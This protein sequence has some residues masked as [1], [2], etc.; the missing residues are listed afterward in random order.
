VAEYGILAFVIYIATSLPIYGAFV[1]ASLFGFSLGE[2]T[3]SAGN[4][5]T[6][7]AALAAAWLMLRALVPARVALTVA[8]TPC[9]ARW[10]KRCRKSKHLAS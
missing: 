7:F 1:A 2:A 4:P 6:V 9:I 5:T 10:Q 3:E 8:V